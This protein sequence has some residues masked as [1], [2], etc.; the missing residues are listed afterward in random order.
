MFTRTA[1]AIMLACA[2]AQAGQ[3]VFSKQP[4][5]PANPTNLTTVFKAGD[6][7]YALFIADSPWRALLKAQDR[8]EAKVMVFMEAPSGEDNQ[9]ITMKTPAAIDSKTLLLDI[10]PEPT[11]MRTYSDPAYE[12]GEGRGYRKIGPIAF[13]YTLGQ[14]KPGKHEIA[15][16]AK[17]F[18]D[19]FAAGKITIEGPDFATY[20]ALH[21][22]LKNAAS[23]NALMP[24]AK[25]VDKAMEA[26]MRKLLA[27]AGWPAVIRLVIVDKDWWLDR[28][29]GGN[30]PIVSR[31]I[32]AAAAAKDA[33]GSYFYKHCT[34]HQ[35][36]LISGGFGPLE[37]T[38]QGVKRKISAANINK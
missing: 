12:Y 35:R 1:I 19:T 2:C 30:S 21:E 5:D 27:N 22:Q 23:A 8:T 31:H 25:M 24:E 29:S 36:K 16:S 20:T 14:L 34:F 28:A 9:Y 3:I 37:L 11:R 4:I 7:I 17:Y 6:P 38:K 18:G 33:D 13:T 15:F 26:T 10:A 32:E